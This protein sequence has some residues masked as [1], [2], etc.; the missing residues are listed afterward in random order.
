PNRACIV[1]ANLVRQAFP[2]LPVVLGGIE[3]SLRRAAHYDF[4]SDSVR[5]ALLFD[6]KADLLLYGMGERSIVEVAERLRDGHDLVGIRGSAWI[7]SPDT[8]GDRL[9]SYEEI[10]ADPRQLLAATLALEAQVQ[11]ADGVLLQAHGSRLLA[12]APPAE[13]LATEELDAVY[14]L[15]FTRLP[16]PDYRE[17]IPAFDFAQSAPET[18][19]AA[20]DY[21][22]D[23]VF[24]GDSRTDG[25]R[26]YSG[27]RGADFL[28]YKALMVFE[29]TGTHS[30]DRKKIPVG[31]TKITVL[32]ALEQKQ[33][34]KV[35]LMFG[36]NELGWNKSSDFADSYGQLIDEVRTRQPGAVIYIESLIPVNPGKCAASKAPYYITNEKISAF[37]EILKEVAA[38]KHAV[39]VDLAAALSDENGV[40]PADATT[41]GIHFK[42]AYYEKWYE[43]LKTHT[44][45]KASY[46]AG[47]AGLTTEEVVP[48]AS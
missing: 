46:D 3:A 30:V 22:D 29:I 19:A 48:H 15:P 24:L 17:P 43:Y 9:P 27:I 16:H 45:E 35:Y 4:W 25:F 31:D 39:Y 26:L 40:L 44:V 38:D 18:A 28:A 32:D 37:N 34:G 7:A 13:P 11:R 8:A 10:Q 42:R 14:E 47:Q 6:A 41:D 1:Y 36:V 20:A 5:R 23:A 12:I 33:Y 2:G 21:F